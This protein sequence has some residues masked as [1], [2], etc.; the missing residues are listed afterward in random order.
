MSLQLPQALIDLEANCGIFAVWMLLEHHSIN[1]E[2]NQLSKLC[3]HD[4]ED[5]TFSIGLAV[6]LK[7][8]GFEVSFYTDQDP[9]MHDK[10]ITSYAE[11]Q[12]LHIPMSDAL[13]YQQIQKLIAQ[14]YFAIVYYDTLQ[15]IG[16]HSLVYSIDDN[17]ICF[18]DSFDAMPKAVFEQQRKAVGIC[19][20]VIIIGEYSLPKRYS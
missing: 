19:Q 2:I 14:G 18:F 6:G 8:L 7:K 17:E 13:N 16:N 15:D 20:Q 9:D 4:D 12:A 11:A 10:E 5:G 1:V 3:C